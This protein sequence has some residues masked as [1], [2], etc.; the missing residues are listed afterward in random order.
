[1]MSILISDAK[2]TKETKDTKDTP[3]MHEPRSTLRSQRKLSRR[4][5]HL[6]G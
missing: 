3:K 2:D 5:P 1:L 6:C 4:A